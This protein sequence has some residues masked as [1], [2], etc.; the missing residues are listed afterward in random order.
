[1][2]TEKMMH[3]IKHQILLCVPQHVINRTQLN[4]WKDAKFLKQQKL[5]LFPTDDES[6]RNQGTPLWTYLFGPG[7]PLWPF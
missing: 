2:L 1:M 6:T 5:L 3:I 4:C 7:Q